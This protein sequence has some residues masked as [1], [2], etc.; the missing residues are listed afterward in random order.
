MFVEC[1]FCHRK[2]PR[3]QYAAHEK[4]HTTLLPDGQMTDH[5]TVAEEDRFQGSLGKVPQVYEHRRCGHAT[6]MP[7]EIIRSYLANPFLYNDTSFCTGCNT[8]VSTKELF[9]TETGESL[10]QY[11]QNLKREHLLKQGVAPQDIRYAADGR[12]L[13]QRNGSGAGKVVLAIFIVLM[14]LG[15]SGVLFVGGV[16]WLAAKAKPRAQPR[17]VAVPPV[18]NF[19]PGNQGQFEDPFKEMHEQMRKQQEANRKMMEDMR[20][21]QEEMRRKL[22]P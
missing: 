11:N 22:R 21:Q 7:E 8:Y 18:V 4:Q 6:G 14:V 2:I 3:G 1:P 5:V 10:F 9:W 19:Q 20:R 15:L 16:V 12:I 13:G 17:P